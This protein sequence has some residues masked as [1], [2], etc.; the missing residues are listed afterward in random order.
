MLVPVNEMGV[1]VRFVEMMPEHGFEVVSIQIAFPDAVIRHTATG[2]VYRAEFEFL[3]SNFVD[4]SHD[5]L[6]CDVIVCWRDD[7]GW[8]GLPVIALSDP[9]TFSVKSVDPK[10]AEIAYLRIR[11][12]MLEAEL[13]KIT[14]QY[15]CRDCEEQFPSKQAYGA[16]LRWKHGNGNGAH[17]EK[18][19]QISVLED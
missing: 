16:H 17:V 13:G 7:L 1:V 19:T 2:K 6:G 9:A 10:D 12:K 11:N 18:S 5:P 15:F 3:A 8:D 4:H 14:G